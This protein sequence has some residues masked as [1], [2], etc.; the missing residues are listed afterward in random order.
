MV[1]RWDLA[2]NSRRIQK[3]ALIIRNGDQAHACLRIGLGF[4]RAGA[5]VQTFFLGAHPPLRGCLLSA[6]LICMQQGGAEHF[7][8][9]R[10]NA[11]GCGLVYRPIEQI[12]D[13]LRSADLVISV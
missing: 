7:S 13:Q 1:Q 12:A 3:V 6:V 4:L 8:D 9:H 11:A 10:A 5:K 2:L